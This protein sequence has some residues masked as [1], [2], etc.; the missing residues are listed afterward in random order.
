MPRSADTITRCVGEINFTLSGGNYIAGTMCN[1]HG[2][3]TVDSSLGVANS[4]AGTC[5]CDKGYI[6]DD[7]GTLGDGESIDVSIYSPSALIMM[8]INGFSLVLIVIAWVFVTSNRNEPVIFYCSYSF[9]KYLIYS[10]FLGFVHVFLAR[11]GKRIN[12]FTFL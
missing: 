12:I 5:V 6:G 2:T 3:C 4:W 11:Q 7:C 10:S 1:G 9:V 8:A